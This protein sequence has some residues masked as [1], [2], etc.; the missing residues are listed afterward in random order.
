LDEQHDLAAGAARL[1]GSPTETELQMRRSGSAGSVLRAVYVGARRTTLR[2]EPAIWDALADVANQRGRSIHE[3][4]TE[5]AVKHPEPNL[6][7]AVRVYIVEFYR[8]KILVRR[9]RSQPK[10][11]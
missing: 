2:L 5:I 11:M 1:L 4:V 8:A 3:L 7:S 10:S 6:S 9:K